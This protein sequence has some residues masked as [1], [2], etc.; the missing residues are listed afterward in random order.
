MKSEE[1]LNEK[2]EKDYKDIIPYELFCQAKEN[3]VK[4]CE[5]AKGIKL[6]RSFKLPQVPDCDEKLKEET[7]KGYL[8]RKLP[9]NQKY[10]DRIKEEYSLICRKGFSSYFLIQKMMV[11]EARRISPKLLG[12]G[13]GSEAVGPGRGSVGGSLISYCLGITD[14]DPIYEGLLFSRF[15]SE[16]R[17]GRKIKLRFNEL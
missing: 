4:I 1:E 16:S 9:K 6:D 11:D 7:Q 10:L 5:K 17:G 15:L 13:D 2:W 12:F 14:V 8:K 3:T